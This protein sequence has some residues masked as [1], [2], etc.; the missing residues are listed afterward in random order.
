VVEHLAA[1]DALVDELRRDLALSEAGDVD[2]RT[3][4]LV[5]VIDAGAQLFG[6]NR[7]AELHAG[8]AELFDRGLHDG[9]LLMFVT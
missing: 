6:R 1:T 5:S 2:L 8:G 3:D 7:N 9:Y 4:V